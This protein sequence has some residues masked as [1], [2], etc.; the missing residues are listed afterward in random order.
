MPLTV[1]HVD[2]VTGKFEVRDNNNIFMGNG[3]AKASKRMPGMITLFFPE[4]V[5]GHII[6]GI[7][8]PIN[9][10]DHIEMEV[11]ASDDK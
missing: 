3:R 9:W 1:K 5:I 4:H 2:P 10:I 6:N 7:R 11:G 8:V